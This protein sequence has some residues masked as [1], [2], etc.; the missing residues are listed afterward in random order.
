MDA[1]IMTSR[2][3]GRRTNRPAL[4]VRCFAEHP[5]L[6]RRLRSLA[7]PGWHIQLLDY[8]GFDVLR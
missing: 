5:N 8:I 7:S 2:T 4:R 3:T 6:L 1:V